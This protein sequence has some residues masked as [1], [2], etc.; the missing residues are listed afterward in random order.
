MSNLLAARATALIGTDFMKTW[1]CLVAVLLVGL[2]AF[3]AE[4]KTFS[5]RDV[6]EQGTPGAVGYVIEGSRAGAEPLYVA[7]ETL[8]D[9]RSI[10]EATVEEQ[11]DGWGI[12][13]TLTAEGGK[14]FGEITKQRVGKRIAILIDGTLYAAPVVVNEI[15]GGS[16]RIS[17][18]FTKDTADKLAAKINSS[19]AR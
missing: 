17:G 10:K 5:L 11:G 12:H 16:V 7:K 4:S 18:V 9:A 1:V 6:V 8:L 19:R 2:S 15:T 13:V 14:R 3:G